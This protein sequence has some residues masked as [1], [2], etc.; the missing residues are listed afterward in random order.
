MVK[1][2]R[3]SSTTVTPAGAARSHSA[4]K[5]STT[6]R[7]RRRAAGH[8]DVADSELGRDVDQGVAGVGRRARG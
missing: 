8:E 2:G 5:R 7:A 1:M 6:A 3:N 4:P